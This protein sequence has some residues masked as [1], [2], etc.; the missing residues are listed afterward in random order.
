MKKKKNKYTRQLELEK[1]RLRLKMKQ[2]E[3]E[4]QKSVV[5]LRAS[6]HPV[7]VASDFA[8]EF[9]DGPIDENDE[10]G[11]QLV[12]RR[13]ELR[14]RR[15]NSLRRVGDIFINALV[16]LED[17]FRD[18]LER[19]DGDDDDDYGNDDI[20]VN[21]KQSSSNAGEWENSNETSQ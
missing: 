21:R 16:A 4:I 3:L 8:L 13:K 18:N 15:I 20:V 5:R 17:A 9:L 12:K 19:F 7:T 6:Y 2:Q 1:E 10:L 14:R 11:Q